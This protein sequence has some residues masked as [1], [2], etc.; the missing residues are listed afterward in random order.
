[1]AFAISGFG[2]HRNS[3]GDRIYGAMFEHRNADDAT[4]YEK[5]SPFSS[6]LALIFNKI[7][8]FHLSS[9]DN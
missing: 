9:F 3:V 4:R 7:S 6:I 2:V 8:V 5:S 1:M